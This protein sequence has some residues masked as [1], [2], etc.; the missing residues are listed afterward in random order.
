[1]IINAKYT[2]KNETERYFFNKVIFFYFFCCEKKYFVY[3]CK[4]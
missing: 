2:K 1:M 3:L 4:Q